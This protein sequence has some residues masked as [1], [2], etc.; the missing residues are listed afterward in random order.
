MAHDLIV[1]GKTLEAND[2]ELDHE[3]TSSMATIL[4]TRLLPPARAAL[5]IVSTAQHMH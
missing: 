3:L 5:A 1:T 4:S 2:L